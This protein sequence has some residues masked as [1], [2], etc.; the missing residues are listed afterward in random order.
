[1]LNILLRIK[2][3][4]PISIII[5]SEVVTIIYLVFVNTSSTNLC[6]RIPTLADVDEK[7]VERIS[8]TDGRVH[9]FTYV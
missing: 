2:G 8:W 6:D 9:Y 7:V 4:I 1:M 3:S 5:V